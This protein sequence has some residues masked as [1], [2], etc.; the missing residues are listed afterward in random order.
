MHFCHFKPF[1]LCQFVMAAPGND[2]FLHFFHILLVEVAAALASELCCEHQAP[3]SSKTLSMLSSL[4]STFL[5]W[6]MGT[7]HLP[8]WLSW[9][10]QSMWL[11]L[12]NGRHYCWYM[13]SCWLQAISSLSVAKG[14]RNPLVHLVTWSFITIGIGW[15]GGKVTILSKL[16]LLHL[17]DGGGG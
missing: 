13:M 16:Q 5:L 11:V 14:K 7:I 10:F 1:S 2:S 6:E 3:T 15:H 4:S 8:Y 12:K 9:E 17:Q